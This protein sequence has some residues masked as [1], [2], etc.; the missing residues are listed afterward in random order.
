[1]R[2]NRELLQVEIKKR[3]KFIHKTFKIFYHTKHNKNVCYLHQNG[4][5]YDLISFS[6]KIFPAMSTLMSTYLSYSVP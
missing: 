5:E 3:V 2:T 4:V 1:M 6:I